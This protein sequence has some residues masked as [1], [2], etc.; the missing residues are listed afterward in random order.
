MKVLAGG[1]KK[2]GVFG[3]ERSSIRIKLNMAYLVGIEVTG[4]ERITVVISKVRSPVTH[5]PSG[6]NLSPTDGGGHAVSRLWEQGFAVEP[7]GKSA[8]KPVN[9]GVVAASSKTVVDGCSGKN[10]AAA[11]EDDIDGVDGPLSIDAN[12]TA[13]RKA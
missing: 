11:G 8:R 10:F 12:I 7:L 1:G 2:L 4:K 6:G 3:S 9:Q 5:H 13:V